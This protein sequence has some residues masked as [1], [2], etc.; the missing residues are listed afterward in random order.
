MT[1]STPTVEVEA[2][3]PYE[4]ALQQL[5]RALQHLQVPPGIAEFLRRPKRELTVNFPVRMDN[6]EIRMFTGYRV[7]HNTVRGPA[8]GG[9]RYHPMV[10]MDEVRALAMWM[11]WKCALMDL[12]Y[13][14]AK[15]GIIVDPRELS[16][17]ELE[18][19]TRR[20][21]YELIP[22]IGPEGD[23]PAPDVNTDAQIM[24]W[25]MDTYV[26]TIG[27]SDPGV[28]TGK[29]VNVGG[30]LGRHE[31]TGRGVMLTV[32][33]A[34]EH[35][36]LPVQGATVAVQGFG[37]VGSIA[38]KLLQEQGATVIAISDV[39]GGIYNPQGLD[40]PDVMKYAWQHNRLVAG[41]PRAE[42]ISNEELLVLDCDVLIPAAL[43]NQITGANAPHVK[44]KV[45]AEGA[46]GPTTPEADDILNQR[47]VLIIPDILCNAGGVT[48]SYLEW[49]QDRQSFFWTEE[50]VNTRL[51]Q[52]MSRSFTAVLEMAQDM[53]VDLR[54]AAYILAVKRVV[55]AIQVRGIYP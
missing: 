28:V 7:Q 48:V 36:G 53:Q 15:G 44:A 3:N 29:P 11:T 13:G 51:E 18:R 25:M 2:A 45:V 20:F 42:P 14:G 52:M 54:T 16:Q 30:S 43:E 6:G 50:E 22:I 46:N 19:M 49:V 12:P 41:Y 31:A 26:M 24:A 40:V 10:S 27:R 5:D 38:A 1:T 39:S 9:I 23:I 47:G 17:A 35:L 34:L 21:A 37:N 4:V 55:D 32:V 8:K 33:R